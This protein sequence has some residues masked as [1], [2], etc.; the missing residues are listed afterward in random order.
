MSTATKRFEYSVRDRKGQL[1]NGRLD[2]PSQTALVTK[3]RGM[4]YTPVTVRETGTGMNR[5]LALPWAKGVK[6]KDLAVMSRQFATMIGSGLSLLRALNILAEQTE[7]PA[8]AKALDDV[9]LGV[10]GGQSLSAAMARH[11]RTS[12]P[13]SSSD[14]RSNQP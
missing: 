5:D 4:G 10:E 2:A 13:R 11:P 7:N 6:L 3:L 14:P 12:R 9:R 1:V 8:L